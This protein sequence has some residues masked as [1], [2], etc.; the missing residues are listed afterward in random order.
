MAKSKAKKP[1]T[2]SRALS[3]AVTFFVIAMVAT[4]L[5]S[6]LFDAFDSFQEGLAKNHTCTSDHI[7][8]V[9]GEDGSLHVTEART[10]SFKGSY[11]LSAITLDPP[12]YKD[13]QP[14]GV[15]VID[16]NG[17]ETE[18]VEVP[19]ESEW[20]YR[21][22]PGDGCWSYDE[23]YD[24]IYAFSSTEDASKT[25]VFDYTYVDAV[26]R[27]ADASELYWQFIPAGWDTD[28]ENAS[29]T[30]TLPVPEGEQ[31]EGGVNVLAYGH[32]D[33][34]GT[35]TFNDDGTV[36]FSVP[37]VKSGEFAELRIAFP[38][39]WTPDVSANNTWHSHVLEGIQQEELQ[40]QQESMV[41]Q[42]LNIMLIVIP[43]LLSVA[44]IV[45]AIVLFLK[46]G[47]EHKP[48]FQ[49]EYWRDVPDKKLHPATVARLWRWNK[50]DANDITATLMRLSAKG[51]IGIE[52]FEVETLGILGSKKET[53]YRLTV[54]DYAKLDGLMEIDKKAFSLVFD[55]VG[56]GH[57]PVSLDNIRAFA[58]ESPREYVR[59]A[60]SWQNAVSYNVSLNRFFEVQGDR[61]KQVFI[62][63]SIGVVVIALIF[64]LLIENFVPLLALIPGAA[65]MFGIAFAMP[66]RS[67]K[68]VEV[69]ARCEALKRWL[70][71]FTALD[72]A[73][74]TDT[75]IWGELLVYAY[76]FGVA[77]QVVEDLNRVAPEI[78][79]DGDFVGVTPWYYMGSYNGYAHVSVGAATSGD[80][81]G[82][83]F[84]N[85]VSTAESAVRA[86]DA[87]SS[88]GFSGGGGGGFSGGGG[89]G[90]GGGGGGF[91]R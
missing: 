8:A 68:A 65:V 32:G 69:Y 51:V 18:L 47:K 43:A 63:V 24:T 72:E 14:N 78:W 5:I 62:G 33:M 86:M 54:R 57:S 10:Y 83:C 52:P 39:A 27:Y 46:Y 15:T 80:F 76:I 37:R 88:G 30:V 6:L 1:G 22:G 36:S 41:K 20:R 58:K 17:A 48:S 38:P 49:D 35:V 2:L 70:K 85:T 89:G 21:G 31:V 16:A 28:T 19:F 67:A 60:D 91:S 79:N 25:F 75:K 90:F 59:A 87:G 3:K 56:G 82:N 50:E 40:W 23:S 26:Q 71:D 13:A 11:E 84:E 4:Q 12:S 73:V 74:P 53:S 7:D 66:R 64:S 81:F 9:V 55:T 61:I 29:A 34:A 42:F 44:M 77:K 45:V